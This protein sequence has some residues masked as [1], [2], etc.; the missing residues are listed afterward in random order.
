[1]TS[2]AQHPDA[3][4]GPPPAWWPVLLLL[5]SVVGCEE[6]PPLVVAPVAYDDLVQG[7][8]AA[9]GCGVKAYPRVKNCVEAYYTLHRRFGMAPLYD[10]IYHC[11]KEASGHCR[12]VFT[13]FGANKDAGSCDASF[14]ARCSG[15]YAV[16]CDL[17]DRRVFAFDCEAVGLK[18]QVKNTQSFEANCSMGGCSSGYAPRCEGDRV[19]TCRDGVIEVEDCKAMGLMCGNNGLGKPACVGSSGKSCQISTYKAS[20]TGSEAHTCEVGKVQVEACDKRHFNKT[21]S[22]GACLATGKACT[23]EFDRCADSKTLK[24]CL[25]GTWHTTDCT[26]LGFGGCAPN[27]VTGAICKETFN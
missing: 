21:C 2:T 15:G 24:Y 26:T 4:K 17:L 20:C 25:D 19:L 8:I 9:T 23:D 13:C 16:S 6:A 18:C 1:M 14:H 22:A 5:L 3:T 10:R 11:V 12:A 27:A 7:C